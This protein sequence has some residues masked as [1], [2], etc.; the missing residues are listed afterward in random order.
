[1]LDLHC[2]LIENEIYRVFFFLLLIDPLGS[3][4]K[5]KKLE[6][7]EKNMFYFLKYVFSKKSQ[8]GIQLFSFLQRFLLKG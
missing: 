8:S 2:V 5:N 6:K 4:M 1:M 3:E 7:E